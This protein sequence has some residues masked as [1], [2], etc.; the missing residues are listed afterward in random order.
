MQA[1]N[2]KTVLMLAIGDFFFLALFIF[3]GEIQHELLNAYNPALRVVVQTLVLA[4]PWLPLAWLLDV[5]S[6]EKVV[7]RGSLWRFLWRTLVVW[8]YAAPLGLVLRAWVYGAPTVLIL[9]ANA[10]LFFGGLFI[11]GWRLIFMWFY[12]RGLRSATQ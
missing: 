1:K 6:I 2:L 5:Y 9:F 10:A 4:I 11:M 7:D 8:L 12:F 3:I